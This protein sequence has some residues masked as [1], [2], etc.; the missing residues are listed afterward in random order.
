MRRR[1]VLNV[2][3]SVTVLLTP[4]PAVAQ[5][6]SS[7]PPA[8]DATALAME[9]QNPVSSLITVRCVQFQQRRRSRQRHAVQ[10]ELST[11]DSVQGNR[12]VGIG[13]TQEQLFLT[14]STP[15]PIILGVGPM[16]PLPTATATPFQTGTFG[17]GSA[18][19][20]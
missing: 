19:S 12:S 9:T 18:R 14:S 11:G 13:D 1:S 4:R 5:Q 7:P 3:V 16:F 20:R 8:Q 17:A 10:F 15:G 6:P 2:L